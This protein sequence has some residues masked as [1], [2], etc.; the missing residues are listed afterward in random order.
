MKYI[1]A[2]LI[3]MILYS[4]KQDKMIRFHSYGSIDIK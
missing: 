3:I 1:I 4:E 2:L